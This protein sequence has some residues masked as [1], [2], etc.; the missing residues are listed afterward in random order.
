MVLQGD[1]MLQEKESAPV[2]GFTLTDTSAAPTLWRHDAQRRIA[3]VNDAALACNLQNE[4]LWPHRIRAEN[5]KKY[6]N[7]EATA[8]KRR[9]PEASSKL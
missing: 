7:D 4:A 1:V 5:R 6:T 9:I 2:E 8:N 3:L